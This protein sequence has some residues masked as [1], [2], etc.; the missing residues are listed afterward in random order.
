[1]SRLSCFILL[2]AV[3]ASVALPSAARAV[4]VDA[5]PTWPIP[6]DTPV[7]PPP[8]PSLPAAVEAPPPADQIADPVTQAATCGDWHVQSSYG[9][10]WL[11]GSTW[12]EYRC[13]YDQ[14]Q[15][16][17]HPCPGTGACDAV[18]YGYPFDCYTTWDQRSD[19]FYW[20][21]SRAVFYGESYSYGVDD[22]NGWSSSSLW[23]WDSPTAKWYV[24]PP[25]SPPSAPPTASF[26]LSCNGLSCSFDGT[27]STPGS[28]SIASYSWTLGDGASVTGATAGHTYARAGTYDVTLTV[29]DTG[30]TSGSTTRSV[31]VTAPRPPA[32]S[33]T[34][35]CTGLTCTFDGSASSAGSGAITNYGW[36][37]GD[38]TAGNGVAATHTYGHQGTYSASLTLM[39]GDGASATLAKDVSVTNLTPTAAFTVSC[40]GLR[41]TVDAGASTDRDGTVVAYGWTF[42]DG[43]AGTGQTTVHDYPKAGTYTVALS[44]TDNVG[45]TASTSQR[46]NPIS[47]NARGYKQGGQQNVDLSWNG[48]VGT[49]FDLYRDDGKVATVQAST[50]TDVVPKAVRTRKYRVCLTGDA[51]CSNEVEVRF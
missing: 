30:G 22:W 21:G 28:A 49:S 15:D 7:A 50:Y 12:W 1:M 42:G 6:S 5:A 32:P 8:I 34:F 51:M 14:Y 18:C 31:T 45:A 25:P 10:R 33:F 48:V 36:A 20:N 29:T 24:V 47:L 26:T 46:I 43:A 39:A 13:T 2:V 9:D 38:G 37:F 35:S 17:P 41:C 3:A 19:Y 44:V 11:A 23:W 27:G 4:V 16:Y 40:A